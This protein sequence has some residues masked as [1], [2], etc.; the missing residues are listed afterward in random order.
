MA[1]LRGILRLTWIVL[2]VPAFSPVCLGGSNT[3]PRAEQDAS[4]PPVIPIG[5]DAFL[6]WERWP[7]LRMGVRASMKSTFDR[8]GGNHNADAAHF[9][10]QLD[11]GRNV[12]LDEAGPGILW[13]VRHNHWHGSPWHYHVDGRETVVTE[14][15]TA[16]PTK[17]VPNSVFEPKKLFPPGLTWTWSTTKGADLSWVPIPFEDH[18]RLDYGRARYG[19]GYFILWKIMP[20]LAN[21]SRPLEGW[22]EQDVPPAEVVD[23]LNRSGTDIAP[24]GEGVTTPEGTLSLGAYETQTVLHTTDAPAMIRRIAFR[25]P[26]EDAVALSK[27]RLRIYWDDRE[28]PSVDAPIGLF[29][30]TGSLMRT[31]DQEHIVKSFP[32]TVRRTDDET[33]FATYFPMPFHKNARIELSNPSGETIEGVSWEVRHV[34]YADPPN[35]VGLFHATY[36]D[37]PHPE[38]GRDLVLLDTRDVEGG[39]DWC[40]HFVGTTYVFTKTG[41]LGTL[42]GD[43]RFYFDD[44]ESPQAQGTGSEE[45][46]G[47]G[48]YWGGRT[49]SLP[50]AGHPVGKPPGEID[51]PVE[52]IHSAYRF[53]LSDLMPFGKNARITLEH[54]GENLS[55]EHYETVAYWYGLDRPGLVLTDEFDVGDEGDERLHDYD[56]PDA[57]DVQTLSSRYEHGVDHIPIRGGRGT[58]ETFPVVTDR[59]RETK[60]HSEFTLK[61]T[62]HN[63]GVLLRRRLDLERPNQRATV[64]VADADDVWQKAGTWYTAGGNTVVFA[65]PN[66]RPEEQRKVDLEI[67]PPVQVVQTSNRRWR[68]DEFLIP[69]RL[70]EG[71]DSIRVRIEHR[72]VNLPLLPGETP[73]EEAWTAYRYLAYCFVMPRTQGR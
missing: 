45:W 46:G 35:W 39:G 21:L 60:T 37:F 36:R 14:S 38:P 27:S 1:F 2:L 16:D 52:A 65:D 31:A 12:A 40:G 24:K 71:R 19:T 54:G 9:L 58:T 13:F 73:A 57:S 64:Y 41:T 55:Q 30:G 43:P 23:L 11:D 5:P 29:F 3:Q 50:F 72:P 22:T 51:T 25:V 18:L 4:E 44:S 47:G 10:R 17:P 56:S 49:M 66:A 33:L 48:D 28:Q 63:L 26:D 53:L 32:M 20:G 70:T 61:L 67:A 62:K 6:Q 15:S 7:Y 8:T 68:E 69:R 59:G 42:E 34:P